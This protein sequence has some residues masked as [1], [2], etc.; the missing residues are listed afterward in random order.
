MRTYGKEGKR[1]KDQ[2]GGIYRMT[3]KDE[4]NPDWHKTDERKLGML[5][6]GICT[7]L[8]IILLA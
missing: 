6:V 1:G 2:G 8:L 3:E 5:L 7:V 4:K